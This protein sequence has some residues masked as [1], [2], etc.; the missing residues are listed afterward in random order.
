MNPFE[1]RSAGPNEDVSTLGLSASVRPLAGGTDLLPLM[2]LGLDRPAQ[3]VDLKTSGLS[4]EIEATDD[5]W[6]VG[7]LVTLRDVQFHEGLRRQA[8][9]L[10]EAVDQAATAQLRNRA[11]LAGNLLQRPRCW[12]FRNEHVHCWLSGGDDC[13]A[14]QGRNEHHAIFERSPCVAVHPSDAAAALIALGATVTVRDG[15]GQRDLAVADL[16][17]PP[18]AER[19]L[20]H[21]L[22]DDALITAVQVPVGAGVRSTYLKAMDRAVWAFALVGVAAAV[23]TEADGSIARIDIVA[24]GV[25]NVPVRLTSV[26]GAL[27][28]QRLDVRTARTAADAATQEAT[29]LS[30]NAYKLPLLRQLTR[31]ALERLTLPA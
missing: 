26:E 20:E 11:T 23:V 9:A 19:R 15:S 29:P 17:V 1:Y 28:G 22:A 7:A 24:S 18:T 30:E 31:R 27:L 13:P 5:G 16:L 10:A 14:R 3:L 8:T 21:V 2:K 6:R 12:Y 4:R 25:A